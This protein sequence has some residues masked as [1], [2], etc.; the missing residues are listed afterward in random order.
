MSIILICIK[1]ISM[2]EAFD[3]ERLFLA[4]RENFWRKPGKE[5]RS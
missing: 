1:I 3:F 2:P 5:Y 4:L